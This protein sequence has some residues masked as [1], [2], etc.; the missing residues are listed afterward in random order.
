MNKQS[1]FGLI[2]VV[3]TVIVIA[4]LSAAGYLFYQGLNKQ[5]NETDS[6]ANSSTESASPTNHDHDSLSQEDHDAMM[7]DWKTY[8]SQTHNFSFKY[9]QNWLVQEETAQEVLETSSDSPRNV[10]VYNADNVHVLGFFDYLGIGCE[11]TPTGNE[12]VETLSVADTEVSVAKDCN[13][14]WHWITADTED[15]NELIITTNFLG[16]QDEDDARMLL[17]S[18]E[19]LSNIAGN[20]T[21][22]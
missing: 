13:S 15:G 11:E 1:G 9:P 3:V 12:P 5:N 8:T 4:V 18:V 17:D 6:S 2:E 10:M 20:A 7:A 14:S 22:P 19:G 21:A 16:K